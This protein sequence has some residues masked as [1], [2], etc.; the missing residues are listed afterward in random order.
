[1]KLRIVVETWPTH[2]PAGPAWGAQARAF[3]S[4]DERGWILAEA[5]GAS[6]HDALCEAVLA[7]IDEHCEKRPGEWSDV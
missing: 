3:T 5:D 6:E 2:E 7:A 1:M 4:E